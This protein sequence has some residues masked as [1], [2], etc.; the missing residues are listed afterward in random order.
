MLL[1]IIGIYWAA[2]NLVTFAVYGI[3]KRRAVKHRWRIREAVL[4]VLALA[5]GSAG[6][7]AGMYF[8]RH[9]TQ[10]WYFRWGNLM[11]LF[12]QAALLYVLMR[13]LL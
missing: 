11:I 1:R 2:V 4:F 9:K 12:A 10:K 6:A 3:D 8:F 13:I 7:L 5:G